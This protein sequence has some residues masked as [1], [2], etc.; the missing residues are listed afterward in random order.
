[1]PYGSDPAFPYTRILKYQP[2]QNNKIPEESGSHEKK[3]EGTICSKKRA[4]FATSPKT[5]SR[6]TRAKLALEL[7]LSL[8]NDISGSQNKVSNQSL[9]I[10]Q[11]V[12]VPPTKR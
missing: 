1:M 9:D 6:K 12:K 10:K 11:E 8:A 2:N 7:Q 3:I 5:V 4:A